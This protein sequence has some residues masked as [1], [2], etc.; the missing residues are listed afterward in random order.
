LGTGT[1]KQQVFLKGNKK[2]W[3]RFYAA[4]MW[5]AGAELSR[6]TATPGCLASKDCSASSGDSL[7]TRTGRD[8]QKSGND[9]SIFCFFERHK[10]IKAVSVQTQQVPP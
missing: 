4:L 5:V 2:K 10:V 1:T 3:G 6:V 7:S 8:W 9:R